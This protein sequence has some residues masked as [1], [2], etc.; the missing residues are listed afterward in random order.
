M[1]FAHFLLYLIGRKESNQTNKQNCKPL[2]TGNP[3]VSVL[4]NSGA[5]KCSTIFKDR[6]HHGLEILS[7]NLFIIIM[8]HPK[9]IVSNIIYLMEVPINIIKLKTFLLH[10]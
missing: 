2:Y 10:S 6:M 9:F 8:V 7:C 4:A 5:E 3:Q 1:S